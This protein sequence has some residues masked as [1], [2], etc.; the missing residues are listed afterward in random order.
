MGRKKQDDIYMRVAKA[1][2]PQTAEHLRRRLTEE[3]AE[4][5]VST[6]EK[7][8]PQPEVEIQKA[9]EPVA[10]INRIP[11]LESASLL[12]YVFEELKNSGKIPANTDLYKIISEHFADPHGKPFANLKQLK[13]NYLN[14]KTG[15]PKGA[16]L[17]DEIIA[18]MEEAN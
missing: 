3:E 12:I 14:S 4:K 5:F 15:K 11:W 16:V 8:Y 10:T 17:F 7:I 6:N 13:Q 2:L 1:I 18:K 9:A